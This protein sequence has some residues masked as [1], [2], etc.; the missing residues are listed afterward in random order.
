LTTLPLPLTG[1]ARSCVPRFSA[2]ARNSAEASCETV[3]QSTRIFG[4]RSGR[5]S[6]PSL[7]S[8]TLSRSSDAETMTKTIS[9]SARSTGLSTIVAPYSVSGSA[10]ARVRL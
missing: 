9:R 4:A 1:A 8:V 6:T 7:P 10:L 5:D 3:E 2:A